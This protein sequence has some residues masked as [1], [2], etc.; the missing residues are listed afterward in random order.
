MEAAGATTLQPAYDRI[1]IAAPLRGSFT[2]ACRAK[3]KMHNTMLAPIAICAASAISAIFSFASAQ[4]ATNTVSLMLKEC[5]WSPSHPT[6]YCDAYMEGV[7]LVMSLNGELW[8]RSPQARATTLSAIALC[9]TPINSTPSGHDLVSVFRG[10]AMAHPR[11]GM[12]DA[13]TAMLHAFS[14]AW[15]CR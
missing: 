4:P 11:S 5:T 14:E 1:A 12:Q 3:L 8:R 15:P 13:D 10:W 6:D 2:P 9:A 7:G